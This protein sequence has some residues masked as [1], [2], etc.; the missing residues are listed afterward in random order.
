MASG[1]IGRNHCHGDIANCVERALIPLVTASL[2]HFV[3]SR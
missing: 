1:N 3:T 2:R